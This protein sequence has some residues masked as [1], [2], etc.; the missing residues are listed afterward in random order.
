MKLKH[1]MFQSTGLAGL[2]IV[3]NSALAQT[4]TQTSAPI[5]NW[6]A[7]ASSADGTKLA[8]VA[9][10]G[11]PIYTSTNGGVTWTP[12][13]A[14][15]QNWFSV[16]S[17]AD[18]TK[19][20]ATANTSPVYASSD[21]GATWTAA[22]NGPITEYLSCVASSADGTK[23]V[24]G[25]YDS[26]HRNGGMSA[27]TDSG[28]A[29]AIL[30]N[31]PAT[32]SVAASADGTKLFVGAGPCFGCASASFEISTNSGAN[33]LATSVTSSFAWSAVA[34]SADGNKLVAMNPNA[35]GL[36]YT[37]SDSGAT[38][39][40]NSSPGES[41]I[42]V[43][44]S[45]DG[46]RL[47]AA[48]GGGFNPGGPSV[49]GPV[50]SSIDSGATWTSNDVPYA[51]SVASSADGSKLVAAANGGGIYTAQFT[52]MPVLSITPSGSNLVLYWTV[53]SIK[54]VLQEN[55]DVIKTH[56]T[57]LVRTPTLILTNLQ[58]QATVPLPSGNRFYRLNH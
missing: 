57:D 37:S 35:N 1:K 32:V 17:S 52:P 19:L 38:W 34:S 44:S 31:A 8:A 33:W 10:C 16:A 56:W 39:T 14:P 15:I 24:V 29:W 6:H 30:A 22:T 48:L 5:T 23:L 43:A 26:V 9:C 18:G 20:V 41:W 11:G 25:F 7:V 13:S 4:W 3:S 45:A 12:T 2:F 36:I 51:F 42:S 46:A 53:P 47:V 55:P 40:T 49:G 21:S 58:Y 28:A 27:S 50:Y 54:F